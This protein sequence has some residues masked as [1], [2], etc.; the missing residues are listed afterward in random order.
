[1]YLA[2]VTDMDNATDSHVDF[3]VEDQGDGWWIAPPVLAC[4]ILGDPAECIHGLP[5][6]HWLVETTPTIR[7]HQREGETNRLLV[8]FYLAE[9]G[10]RRG[11]WATGSLPAYPVDPRVPTDRMEFDTFEL[12]PGV[13]LEVRRPGD[14]STERKPSHATKPV[15][16]TQADLTL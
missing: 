10:P 1:M 14:Q 3:Y 16:A 13:K 6:P 2:K 8:R 12:W 15:G 11:D 5:D 4:R 9:N 7:H